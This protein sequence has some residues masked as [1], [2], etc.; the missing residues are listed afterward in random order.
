[1]AADSTHDG[2]VLPKHPHPCRP[3]H[4]IR[5]RIHRRPRWRPHSSNFARSSCRPEGTPVDPTAAEW[6]DIEKGVVLLLGGSIFAAAAGTPGRRVHAGIRAGRTLATRVRRRS[7]FRTARPRTARRSGFPNGILVFSPFEVVFEALGRAQLATL[8]QGDRRAARRGRPWQHGA[9][10]GQGLRPGGLPADLR[11]RAGAVLRLR[12][13]GGHRR[14]GQ[15]RRQHPARLR[16]RLFQAV[17]RDSRE[18]PRAG[19]AR[20]A[21]RPQATARRGGDGRA[22]CARTPA[23]RIRHPGGRRA[24][25]HRDRPG[26]I[27]GATAA[28]LAARGGRGQ[29]C[30]RPTTKISLRTKRA[31]IRCCSTSIWCPIRSPRPTRTACWGC[32]P[33]RT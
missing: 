1:M 13:E 12:S 7:G 6:S 5:H 2:I 9:G 18:S 17:E 24:G 30:R 20:S 21:R 15:H 32:F 10:R 16:T 4:R 19:L 23:D 28:A 11:S 22:D 3:H 29:L 27:L 14:A 8:T 31:S 26:R 25:R 33:P